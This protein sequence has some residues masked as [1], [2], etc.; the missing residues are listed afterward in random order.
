MIELIQ[1]D[2]MDYMKTCKDNEFDLAI[3]DPPYRDSNQ[4]TKD[5]RKNG[6]MKSLEGRPTKEYFT[7]LNR[8]SKNQII[9]GANNF[10]LPQFMGFVVW[11]K[12]TISENFTM[13]MAEIASISKGLGTTSKIYKQQP[14]EKGRIHPT[15]KPVKLYQWLLDRY[16]KPTDRILDTHL[17][18]ASSA[19]A[20]HYFSCEFVGIELDKDY[21]TAAKERF[22]LA[23]KQNTFEF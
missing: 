7:E 16:A 19:I 14:Q 23:T 3:V 8:V 13:S 15:Q 4:P 18:S 21:Y 10:E 9:W 20:A 5:M 11:E 17:G 1:G 2:C 12:I 22:N 6:S